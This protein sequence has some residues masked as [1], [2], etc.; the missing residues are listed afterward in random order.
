MK[1][2]LT[3]IIAA[4]IVVAGIALFSPDIPDISVNIPDY[5]AQSGPEHYNEQYFYNTV[6][7]YDNLT[8]GGDVTALGTLATTTLTA[9]NLCNSSVLTVTGTASSGAVTLPSAATMF[10]DCLSENGQYRSVLIDNAGVAT[11]SIQ[12]TAGASTTLISEAVG[13]DDINGGATG[14]LRL[15]RVSATEMIIYISEL[16]DSDS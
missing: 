16:I 2:T 14:L 10:A 15:F 11:S 5:G 4:L 3:I 8:F 1:D 7:F 13:G 6:D 12:L 9:A